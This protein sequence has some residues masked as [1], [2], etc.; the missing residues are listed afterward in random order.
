MDAG[1][2][3]SL[4]ADVTVSEGLD[5]RLAPERNFHVAAPAAAIS[6]GAADPARTLANAIAGALAPMGTVGAARGPAEPTGAL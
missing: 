6:D 2:V 1:S 4:A 3:H 5:D